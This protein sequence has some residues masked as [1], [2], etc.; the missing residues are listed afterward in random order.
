E[1][2]LA[3]NIIDVRHRPGIE[4]PVADG[5]SRMWQ[6]K[7]RTATDG[8]TWS[9]LADWEA[10]KGIRN[11]ILSVSPAQ[12]EP[13]QPTAN[14]QLEERFRGDVFFEPMVRHLLGSNT[15]STVSERRCAMHRAQGFIV[16]QGKLWKVASRP[17][18]RV[19]RREC[20]PRAEGFQFA[21][22]THRQIGH[23]RSVDSLKL[24]IHETTFWPGM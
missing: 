19:S 6:G 16:D 12:E 4:N 15:G 22:D 7:K 1:S 9:V 18:E 17:T 3:H 23:F 14:V 13:T 8:S 21:L 2:I 11:N 24:H 5:L 10:I 20:I